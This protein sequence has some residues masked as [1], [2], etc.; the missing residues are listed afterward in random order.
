LLYYSQKFK[1]SG[2]LYDDLLSENRLS[3]SSCY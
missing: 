3:T 1:T 2:L